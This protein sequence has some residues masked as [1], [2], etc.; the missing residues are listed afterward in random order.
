MRRGDAAD[1]V[2]AE[3]R[4]RCDPPQRDQGP[5]GPRAGC[6]SGVLLP[7]RF[8]LDHYVN[9]RPGEALPQ[10]RRSAVEQVAPGNIPTSSSFT[11]RAPRADTSRQQRRRPGQHAQRDRD[12]VSVNASSG[13]GRS[14]AARPACAG[15]PAQ[16]PDAGPTSCVTSST[17]AP[18]AADGEV[19]LSSPMSDRLSARVDARAAVGHSPPAGRF[20]VIVTDQPLRQRRCH[21]TS[22]R[23]SPVA[24]NSPPAAISTRADRAE[25]VRTRPRLRARHI[26]RQ[27]HTPR[28]RFC[29]SRCC[30]R[31]W[32]MRREPPVSNRPNRRRPR[33]S[34]PPPDGTSQ[35]RRRDRRPAPDRDPFRRSH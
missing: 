12:E 13:S 1:N 27:G 31:I 15:P 21:P 10:R 22:P 14:S 28:P 2:I 11:R 25:H 34:G 26:A 9:L 5:D 33:R 24:S 8:A 19:R 32:D 20:D 6:S 23:R 18:V 35:I 4:G 30:S 16:A 29:R 3:L 17:R 7:L